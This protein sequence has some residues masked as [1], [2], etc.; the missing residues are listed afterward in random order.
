[1]IQRGWPKDEEKPELSGWLD[2]Q[3][4]ND[5]PAWLDQ[6]A[7]KPV[8]LVQDPRRVTLSSLFQGTGHP[9]TVGQLLVARGLQ[10]Q[11]EGHPEE[12][13]RSLRRGLVV[14]RNL[15]YRSTYFMVSQ[16]RTVE[17][18]LLVGL[19]HWLEALGEGPAERALLEQA[20][21][22]L[23][24]HEASTPTD[25]ADQQKAD[26]LV[27]LNSLDAAEEWA[28]HSFDRGIGPRQSNPITPA[29]LRVAWSVPWE[30]ARQERILRALI[31]GDLGQQ[32][33]ATRLGHGIVPFFFGHYRDA[34]ERQLHRTCRLHAAQLQVALRLYQADH[35]GQPADR[36]ALLVNRYL[37]EVPRDPF[38][39]APFRYRLSQGEAIPWPGQPVQRPGGARRPA[40]DEP[41]PP[42]PRAPG[43]FAP[44]GPP[45]PPEEPA[46]WV[47]KG[48]G[49]LWSVGTDRR[50]DGG[51]RQVNSRGGGRNEGEDIIFLVPAPAKKG[52]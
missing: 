27:S 5:W 36:L 38:A 25:A 13:V 3:F 4:T 11:A 2:K 45:G 29:V 42:G 50:D 10:R 7:A 22:L 47:P 12:Y 17:Q 33:A 19:E 21:E 49:I 35:K 8:G 32:R 20:L 16:G 46:K 44:G 6:A 37:R 43:G 28:S 24:A 39:D 14:S 30:R 51:K 18:Y 40:A 9:V 34:E 52:P 26:Y 41:A 23:L 48:W 15:Q 31:W 1:V